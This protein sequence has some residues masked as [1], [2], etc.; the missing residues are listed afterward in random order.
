L[1]SQVLSKENLQLLIHWTT[2]FHQFLS[3]ALVGIFPQNPNNSNNVWACLRTLDSFGIHRADVI[4]NEIY[5]DEV[6]KFK[7]KE[8]VVAAMGVQRWTDINTHKSSVECLGL[9]RSQGYRLIATDV[10][11]SSKPIHEINW[12]GKIAGLVTLL[13]LLML[14]LTSANH[15]FRIASRIL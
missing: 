8:Q 10:Q 9:L 2:S 11:P 3:N 12:E 13:W 5:R 1:C 4:H 7:G 14:L 15:N 6:K